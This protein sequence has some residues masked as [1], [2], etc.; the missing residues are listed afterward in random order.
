MGA[1][2]INNK[3]VTAPH[4]GRLPS[5]RTL[6]LLFSGLIIVIVFVLYFNALGNG[7]VYDDR[8]FIVKNPLIR[9]ISNVSGIF[10]T[11]YWYASSGETA[12]A[13]LLYRP[14]SILSFA[15]NYRINGLDPFGYHFVNIVLHLVNSLLVYLLIYLIIKQP[16]LAAL[17]AILFAA[18]PVHTEAVTYVSGRS[19]LLSAGLMLLAW[20]FYV[21]RQE[22]EGSRRMYLSLFSM[23]AFLGAL[24]SK[25]TAL[26]LLGVLLCY[27][28]IRQLVI[29]QHGRDHK[30]VAS[31]FLA[32]LRKDWIIYLG[33]AAVAVVYFGLRFLVLH[34]L[35]DRATPF[36]LVHED[37]Y[38][39]FLLSLKVLGKYLVLTVFPWGL[40]PDYSFNQVPVPATVFEWEVLLA[41]AV[42]GSVLGAA[43]WAMRTIPWV[44]F[45]MFLFFLSLFPAVNGWIVI[46]AERLLYFPSLGFC[47][48][49]GAV[50]MRI[51]EQGSTRIQRY[52][53]AIG[54]AFIL[55]IAGYLT[56][57]RNRDWANDLAL[58]SRAVQTVPM[59]AKVH[60]NLGV[61]FLDNGKPNL[62]IQGFQD[63]IRILPRYAMAHFNL[64]GAYASVGQLHEATQVYLG[65]LQIAPRFVQARLQ[66]GVLYFR[67]GKLNEAILEYQ[68]ALKVDS[69]S[70]MGHHLLGNAYGAQGR[71]R[72][73]IEEFQQVL[74]INPE[75]ADSYEGMAMAYMASGERDR[76]IQA[77]EA[78]LRID[79][80]RAEPRLFLGGLYL[81]RGNVDAAI[82]QF[83][84]VIRINPR[85]EGA[86][87]QLG[88]AYALQGRLHEAEK[89]F[90]AVLQINSNNRRARERL[91]ALRRHAYS[92]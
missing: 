8:V 35:A 71:Y 5:H 21:L 77:F 7:F 90:L 65:L 3:L 64:A 84:A 1:K 4:A 16:V 10:S 88:D 76:S 74:Q 60:N 44:A 87:F 19:D 27:E 83:L 58:W 57:D 22:T 59:S 41:L 54:G 79:P 33:F 30:S 2:P 56:V 31:A 23:G 73:A 25:E 42:L 52:S 82:H 62:A 20:F 47:L 92:E 9:S 12:S 63:A 49:V 40:S 11:H 37:L 15:L 80:A 34:P 72:E 78:A 32:R 14:L 70:A 53:L 66:L 91:D 13:H 6:H 68:K 17:V 28:W 48:A 75:S 39:R 69:R 29:A 43:R 26:V 86:Y 38:E 51:W 61:A 81:Q 85:L 36:I 89:A 18:H 55:V 50:G 46:L 67:Q 45:G 24:M